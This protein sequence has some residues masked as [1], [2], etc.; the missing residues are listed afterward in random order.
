VPS[1]RGNSLA[2]AQQLQAA[3]WAT[4]VSRLRS[5]ESQGTCSP[6]NFEFAISSTN[7]VHRATALYQ[8]QATKARAPVGPGMPPSPYLRVSSR[9]SAMSRAVLDS[10]LTKAY[11][12]SGRSFMPEHSEPRRTSG[13]AH[14]SA[15]PSSSLDRTYMSS[16]VDF[17]VSRSGRSNSPDTVAKHPRHSIPHAGTT[18]GSRIKVPVATNGQPAS[19]LLT[20]ASNS[21][22]KRPSPYLMAGRAA[23]PPHLLRSG[24]SGVPRETGGSKGGVH[25]SATLSSTLSCPRLE[26]SPLT[27]SIHGHVR[28]RPSTTDA[29]NV[30]HNGCQGLSHASP[31]NAEQQ[32]Y[33]M[34]DMS[35]GSVATVA[36][37]AETPLALA[38]ASMPS[39]SSRQFPIFSPTGSHCWEG[40]VATEDSGGAP[41]LATRPEHEQR[42]PA[43]DMPQTTAVQVPVGHRENEGSTHVAGVH[44]SSSREFDAQA[45]SDMTGFVAASGRPLW[46]PKVQQSTTDGC[47]DVPPSH[48]PHSHQ[49]VGP[50][51]TPFG[52][53][54]LPQASLLT[55]AASVAGGARGARSYGSGA[56]GDG[57][58]LG[59]AMSGSDTAD[60]RPAGGAGD[61]VHQ[62]FLATATKAAMSLKGI[63]HS[64]AP[65]FAGRGAAHLASCADG[66][67]RRTAQALRGCAL[68]PGHRASSHTHTMDGAQMHAKQRMGTGAVPTNVGTEHD[69]P[70]S[71]DDVDPSRSYG[72]SIGCTQGTLQE[73]CEAQIPARTPAKAVVAVVTWQGAGGETMPDPVAVSMQP[74]AAVT[75]KAWRGM[76]ARNQEAGLKG[77]DVEGAAD[78]RGDGEGRA[79]Q[80]RSESPLYCCQD[81]HQREQRFQ[82][83]SAAMGDG[84]GVARGVA[85]QS[86]GGLQPLCFDAD[87]AFVVRYI[88]HLHIRHAAESLCCAHLSLPNSE[89]RLDACA[90]TSD[91][92]SGPSLQERSLNNGRQLLYANTASQR[93]RLSLISRPG[94]SCVSRSQDVT[95]GPQSPGA[96]NVH[97]VSTAGR[98]TCRSVQVQR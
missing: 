30:R 21:A 67:P 18:A 54:A 2:E 31:N 14:Q 35:A 12:A 20:T 59:R 28:S 93:S 62:G 70:T 15:E 56:G 36:G 72:Q 86:D 48:V 84:G 88:V 25:R 13:P 51:G 80:W 98:Q 66:L 68:V 39:P 37:S 7:P 87:G 82:A 9:E 64:A 96:G 5:A 83:G 16:A 77:G 27:L 40:G 76:Q 42:L 29:T 47:D 73:G 44:K 33:V 69:R 19:T 11:K 53:M 90:L 23:S 74:Q 17:S 58:T 63:M 89:R 45:S 26:E 34:R 92:S 50:A 43:S 6:G 3:S 41:S 75:T 81:G 71:D 78:G 32:H 94:H 57:A 65:F 79:R 91:T 10:A 8:P 60:V 61:A 95:L 4:P 49:A 97:T 85:G 24:G 52:A 38:A 1:T 22:S 55:R 46:Q